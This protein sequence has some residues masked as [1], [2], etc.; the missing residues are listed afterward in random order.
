VR[1][2]REAWLKERA[3]WDPAHLVF[4]DETGLTTAMVR[5]HGWG[6]RGKRV[7]GTAPQG[8]WHT[9]T[10][11]A[12]LRQTGLTAPMVTEGPMTGDL[13]LAYVREFLAPSLSPG[14]RVICDNLASHL[15]AGVRD[16]IEARGAIF[17]P[18]PP[19]SPD[20]NPIEQVFSKLKAALRK[21][22]TRT[23]EALYAAVA[24]ALEHFPPAEC[25]HY[26][27]GAGYAVQAR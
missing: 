4:L 2:R 18:L 14:D 8:H 24:E 11:V 1:V 22:A 27:R 12:A 10:F 23:R 6:P 26:A 17:L 20:L 7:V 15:G 9:T 16:A 25:A 13:F 3:H 19:Y 21:A 5:R